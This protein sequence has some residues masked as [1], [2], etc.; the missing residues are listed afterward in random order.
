MSMDEFQEV[1]V[2]IPVPR[3]ANDYEIRD[4][5]NILASIAFAERGINVPLNRIRELRLSIRFA[6]RMPQDLDNAA[7]PII[8]AICPQ[9]VRR[10]QGPSISVPQGKTGNRVAEAEWNQGKQ[11]ETVTILVDDNHAVIPRMVFEAHAGTDI[12]E[13]YAM[14]TIV[15]D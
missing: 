3:D 4:Q 13:G 7:K 2:V 11:A 12:E 6:K 1:E 8:D 10:D 9:T 14:L 5:I 15:L